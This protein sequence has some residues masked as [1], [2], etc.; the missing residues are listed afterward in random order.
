MLNV[1]DMLSVVTFEYFKANSHHSEYRG[2]RIGRLRA[3][4]LTI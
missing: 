1:N 3:N 4:F 2:T